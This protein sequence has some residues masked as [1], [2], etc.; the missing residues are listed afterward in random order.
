MM[1]ERLVDAG[2]PPESLSPAG[3]RVAEAFAASIANRTAFDEPYRHFLIENCFP[4][5]VVD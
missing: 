5:D 4:R 3:A 2:L 1:S